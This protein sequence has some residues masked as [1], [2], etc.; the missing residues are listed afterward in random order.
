M[1]EQSYGQNIPAHWVHQKT[2]SLM[3]RRSAEQ[4]SL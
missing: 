3:R 1:D 4:R 2:W